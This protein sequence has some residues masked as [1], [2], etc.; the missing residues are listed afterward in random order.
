MLARAW[1]EGG[2]ANPPELP[3]SKPTEPSAPDRAALKAQLVEAIRDVEALYGDGYDTRHEPLKEA[4]KQA[5]RVVAQL[6]P[7]GEVVEF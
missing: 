3:T 2:A 6:V 5:L 7:V 1:C 4:E